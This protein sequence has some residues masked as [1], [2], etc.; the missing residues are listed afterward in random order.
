MGNEQENGAS[1]SSAEGGCIECIPQSRAEYSYFI[2]VHLLRD[3]RIQS[4]ENSVGL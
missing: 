3:L 2:N 4:Q 1:Q